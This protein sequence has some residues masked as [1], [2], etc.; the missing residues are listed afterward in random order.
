MYSFSGVTTRQTKD[1][2]RPLKCITDAPAIVDFRQIASLLDS[3]RALGSAR[4]LDELLAL[5]IDSAIEV[6]G[7]E[8]G[9]IML[10]NTAQQ[11][12]L[13]LVRARGKMTLGGR[14]LTGS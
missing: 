14:T 4:V 10:G 2:K 5:V 7:A 11:L 13:N 12:E 1:L 9:F 6:T 8:R 3:L